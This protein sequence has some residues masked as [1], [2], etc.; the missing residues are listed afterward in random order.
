LLK[1]NGRLG[2]EL[3]G[4]NVIKSLLKEK[5]DKINALTQE[6]TCLKK[7]SPINLHKQCEQTINLLETQVKLLETERNKY[8]NHRDDLVS[9]VGKRVGDIMNEHMGTSLMSGHDGYKNACGPF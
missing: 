1:E 7:G 4:L 3:S 6:V 8:R 2:G 5:E 9:M